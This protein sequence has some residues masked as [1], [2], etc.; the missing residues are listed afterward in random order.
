[1]RK[2]VPSFILLLLIF[3]CSKELET[4]DFS[5]EEQQN[6]NHIELLYKHEISDIDLKFNVTKNLST[7]KILFP[8]E[9]NNSIIK[10]ESYYS[11][12]LNDTALQ[13]IEINTGVFAEVR[14]EKG[15]PSYTFE[16]ELPDTTTSSKGK[17][18]LHTYYDENNQLKS[19]LIR[20]DLT[21]DEF[22]MAIKNKSYDGFWDKIFFMELSY[23][24]ET[25]DL[26]EKKSDNDSIQNI[27]KLSTQSLASARKCSCQN[28]GTPAPKWTPLPTGKGYP[29]ST[30]SGIGY[31][32]PPLNTLPYHVTASLK[33]AGVFMGS[34]TIGIG[35]GH[36]SPV[37]HTQPV[38]TF[39][40]QDIR[41]PRN[42]T[43]SSYVPFQYFYSYKMTGLK[44]TISEYYKKVYVS[45]INSYINSEKTSI[46]D[47]AKKQSYITQFF[48]FMHELKAQKPASFEYLEE[49]PSILKSMFYFLEEDNEIQNNFTTRKDFAEAAIEALENGGEVDFEDKIIND[50]S[51][52]AKCVYDRLENLS[53]GFKNMIKK[54]DGEFPVSH[55]KFT[56]GVEP[57][58]PNANA[59][60]YP[61]VAYITEIK[62]NPNNL[63]RPNLSIARTFVHEIIHAEMFRKLLSLSS[64]NGQIDVVNLRQMLQRGD[65]PGIFDYYTRFGVNGFQHEQM[66]AHYRRTIIE[67]L[68][69]VQPGLNNDIYNSLAWAG[70][71]GTAAWNNL[72]NEERLRIQRM[73]SNFDNNGSE[74]CN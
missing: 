9:S 31:V 53:G 13:K 68:K 17:F 5:N 50:L 48:Y 40:V 1:M 43:G 60:T 37:N 72:S 26:E 45:Q 2:I 56:L 33:A 3:G 18:N 58:S 16:V 14:N 39:S 59:V 11:R 21:P 24:D 63:N 35:A 23:V 20:Y 61:P 74:N 4:E 19:N 49:N 7:L 6:D 47:H 44:N 66:A 73:Y 46:V 38:L 27:N 30:A 32:L 69:V 28:G 65:Y 55:L 41:I 70:L 34:Y 25:E 22:V 51:G 29:G 12:Y 62:I 15:I 36:S 10:S 64:S 42:T 57:R 8:A 71:H 52:K 54:F 67:V